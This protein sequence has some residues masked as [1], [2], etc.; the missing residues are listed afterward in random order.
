[1][2]TISRFRNPD[3]KTH[4]AEKP[5]PHRKQHKQKQTSNEKKKNISNCRKAERERIEKKDWRKKKKPKI[6]T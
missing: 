6:K 1:L 5:N 3:N 4:I 2:K